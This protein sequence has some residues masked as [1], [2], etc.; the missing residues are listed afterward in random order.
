VTE[1]TDSRGRIIPSGVQRLPSGILPPNFSYAGRRYDGPRWTP[2]L[3]AKYPAGVRFTDDGFPDFGPYAMH[4][5]VFEPNFLG[6][7]S[8]DFTEAN[9]KA[10]LRRTPEGHTW[11]HHQDTRTMQLVPT[12]IHRAVDHGGGVAIMKGRITPL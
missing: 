7:R 3:A 11:H 12:D 6:N 4:T 5:V 10:G 2:K 9:R 8:S 1:R